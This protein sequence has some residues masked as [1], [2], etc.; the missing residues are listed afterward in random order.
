MGDVLLSAFYVAFGF[1]KPPLQFSAV[2]SVSSP[3][4]RK[5]PRNGGAEV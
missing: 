1:L 2:H 5:A 4:Q 3:S